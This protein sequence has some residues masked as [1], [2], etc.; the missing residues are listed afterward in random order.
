MIIITGIS[1]PD[2]FHT[3]INMKGLHCLEFHQYLPKGISGVQENNG[4]HILKV[5]S[6]N[7][8]NLPNITLY[9]DNHMGILILWIHYLP[10]MK[11][12]M[13]DSWRRLFTWEN[14]LQEIGLGKYS[15]LCLGAL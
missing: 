5:L 2:S 11:Q 6:F 10:V 1:Q 4:E 15:L 9:I 8:L 3:V 7:R 12:L 13:L 14:Y